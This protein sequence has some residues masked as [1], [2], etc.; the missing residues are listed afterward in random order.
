MNYKE[1]ESIIAGKEKIFISSHINPDGDSLGSASAMYH[2]LKKLGKDCRIINHS[3][4]PEVYNFLNT[5][6]IFY[7]LDGDNAG[8]IKNADLGI[9]LDIGDFYRLGDIAYLVEDNDIET[10]SIDHH[11]QSDN[12]LF[13]NTFIDLNACS[14]GEILYSYFCNINKTL[15]DKNIMLGLYVA[16]LTDT[17]SFRH[18]NTTEISHQIAVD[19]ISMKIEIS[20]IYQHIYESSS[21]SRIK[22]LGNVIQNLNFDCNGELAWFSLNEDM[23][24]EVNGSN[25]DFDGFTDFFRSIKGVEVSLMLYDLKGKVRLS[26]RSK[27]KYKVSE[28]AKKMGGG[29]HPFAAAALV[30]GEFSDV[31]SNV[32]SMLSTYI[33][34]HN[35]DNI[36]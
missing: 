11:P 1:I 3:P 35:E 34:K 12:D 16:V 2:H 31:K 5:D 9:I 10:L 22:L 15:I 14:V 33:N 18:S 25:Q 23:V 4:M 32:L 30:E 17:G 27:G 24:K 19:A 13:T 26:F 6:N 28:I 20:K 36:S 7:E 29:G 8:F 21:V